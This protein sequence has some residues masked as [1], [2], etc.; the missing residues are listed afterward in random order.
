MSRGLPRLGNVT[1]SRYVGSHASFQ[2]WLIQWCEALGVSAP[3]LPTKSYR[4]E[5]PVRVI[6]RDGREF[7]NFIDCWKAGHFAL[8]AKATEVADANEQP[9]RKAFGQVR[10]YVAHTK[11]TAPP[12]LLVVDVPRTLIVW[13]RWSGEYGGFPAGYRINLTTLSERPQD[14][15]TNP[16]SGTHRACA[17]RDAGDCRQACT[18][19][20]HF[21][22]AWS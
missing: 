10:N 3:V 14:I 5:Y 17:N 9:L 13:D 1:D 16:P 15:L 20:R 21:R 2:P 19:R 12:F 22:G 7:T 8:E 11:G 18:T 6:D 4:F